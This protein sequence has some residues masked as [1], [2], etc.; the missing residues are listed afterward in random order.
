MARSLE[1]TAKADPV[2]RKMKD[3][4]VLIEE[5]RLPHAE[6]EAKALLRSNPSRPEIHSLLGEIYIRQ[7]KQNLAVPHFEFAVKAKPQNPAFL[8]NL[9]RLYLDL[10]AVELAL[11]FLQNAL[12]ID[13]NLIAALLALGRYYFVIGKA[14]LA[15]PYLERAIKVDLRN[16]KAKWNLAESFDALGKKS[17]ANTLYR[18]LRLLPKYEA[19]SLSRLA[20]NVTP[21]ESES[22]LK[23]A[24]GLLNATHISDRDRSVV[25]RSIGFLLEKKGEYEAAFEH[26]LKSNELAF[27]PFDIA[28]YRAWIDEVIRHMTGDIFLRRVAAGNQ[29]EL[30]VFVLGMPRSGTTLAE[31]IIASHP[32]AGG[33]GELSRIWNFTMRFNYR[34]EKDLSRFEASL[35]ALGANALPDM[36]ENYLNLLNLHAPGALRIVDRTPHNFQALGLIAVLFPNAR[37]IHCVRNPIDTCLSCFQQPLNDKL[38]F[39]KDLTTL[40]LYY[41]EYVR[42]MNHWR[43]V[44]PLRFYELNYEKVTEDF[45]IEARKLIDFLGL[46]WDDR[47]LNFHE[48][49]STVLGFSRHQVRN[50]VYRSS[51]ERWRR[52]E[53]ELQP[54]ITALGDLV[55]MRQSA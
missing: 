43:K 23:D 2:H 34:R 55:E 27:G 50:P 36:A 7:K 9:G 33:A 53:K 3:L 6:S 24:E 41:R 48:A 8:S 35:K 21:D 18:E 54:L 51:V 47:C 15:L 46:P 19:S 42:L 20:S 26:F 32:R 10:E 16:H 39:N 29:S 1:N 5:G 38:K 30:P 25:H 52:Y 14:D 44:L 17:E 4:L 22:V 13:P 31:Q 28:G 49:G 37:V 40:G 12:A 45:G 11:P